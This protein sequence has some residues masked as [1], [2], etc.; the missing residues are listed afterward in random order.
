MNFALSLDFLYFRPLFSS[1]NDSLL[2]IQCDCGQLCGELIACARYRVEDEREKAKKHIC[3]PTHVLFIIHYPHK[4]G[5]TA[6]T[7]FV[8][9]QG[10]NWIYAHID[11]IRVS[12][13]P[14]FLND[15]QNMP[16]SRLFYSGT[17][18]TNIKEYQQVLSSEKTA[19]EESFDKLESEPSNGNLDS[20][21]QSSAVL[22]TKEELPEIVCGTSEDIKNYETK[23]EQLAE[24]QS[25]YKLDENGKVNHFILII[26]FIKTDAL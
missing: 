18:A 25:S 16:I 10:G 22:E 14:D 15:A 17:F 12:F 3:S 9:F 7:S 21:G 1:Q 24:N 23:V 5:I 11:D 4:P 20:I 13:Y 6:R 2:I 8:G 26:N 19:I